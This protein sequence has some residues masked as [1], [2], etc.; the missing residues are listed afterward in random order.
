MNRKLGTDTR[1]PKEVLSVAVA[2]YLIQWISTAL[3]PSLVPAML[4]ENG[5]TRWY[6]DNATS[7]VNTGKLAWTFFPM[8]TSILLAPLYFLGLSPGAIVQWVH[9]L[10]H[11]G[12]GVLAMSI[13]K[14]FSRPL[15]WYAGAA[16]IIYPTLLNY[17]RQLLSECYVVLV[18]M[19]ALAILVRPGARNAFVGGCLVGLAVLVRSPI[20]GVAAIIILILVIVRRPF[21]EVALAGCGI[22]LLLALGVGIASYTDGRFVFLTSGT[23]MATSIKSV[24]GGYVA[25]PTEERAESYLQILRD[26]WRG[27]L[28]QRAHAAINIISP[29]PL[30]DRTLLTKLAI[31]LP[32]TLILALGCCGSWFAFKDRRRDGVWLLL[33]P[34]IGLVCFHTLLFAISRYRMPYFPPLICFAVITCGSRIGHLTNSARSLIGMKPR[35]HPSHSEG[36]THT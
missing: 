6:W 21:K 11:A 9:P 30:D 24:Y 32:E 29:W 19:A 27:F 10:I 2:A 26:D 35:L 20:L 28:T 3:F 16:V 4:Y 12:I 5:D 31:A 1:Y 23:S 17:G 8:G 34:V 36:D 13:V 25:V 15:A 33:S 18:L 22:C 14:H 7:L